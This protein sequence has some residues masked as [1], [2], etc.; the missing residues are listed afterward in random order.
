MINQSKI[1]RKSIDVSLK[2]RKQ[3][4]NKKIQKPKYRKYIVK[5]KWKEH[6]SNRPLCAR[7]DEYIWDYGQVIYSIV[8]ENMDKEYREDC[9]RFAIQLREIDEEIKHLIQY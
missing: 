7:D 3:R 2:T 1:C 6:R 8:M 9:A 5:P 4:R